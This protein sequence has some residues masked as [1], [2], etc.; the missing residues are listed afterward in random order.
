MDQATLDARRHRSPEPE[1]HAVALPV[2]GL[3]LYVVPCQF[4]PADAMAGT[5]TEYQAAVDKLAEQWRR[6]DLF[7]SKVDGTALADVAWGAVATAYDLTREELECLVAG[8]G[9]KA[10]DLVVSLAAAACGRMPS[11]LRT[12]RR[13]ALWACMI[14]LSSV[15]ITP[16][17]MAILADWAENTGN[18]PRG[19]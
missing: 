9:D 4:T 17:E 14:G 2:A 11:V 3:V 12:R 13:R 10:A 7:K 16:D 18:A 19:G 15:A 8:E 6:A 5:L 1:A